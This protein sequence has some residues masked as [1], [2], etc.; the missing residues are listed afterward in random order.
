MYSCHDRRVA[1]LIILLFRCA[2][3]CESS[4][5]G[6]ERETDHL[7]EELRKA[8]EGCATEPEAQNT[9]EF[10]DTGKQNQNE[11]T[12]DELLLCRMPSTDLLS[13][14]LE[15]FGLSEGFREL[16]IHFDPEFTVSNLN[17]PR[18]DEIQFVRIL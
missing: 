13:L 4:Q 15:A 7:L 5:T 14:D 11:G 10:S 2:V 9:I 3:F 18:V 1:S 8:S 6:P 16:R 17:S 12:A